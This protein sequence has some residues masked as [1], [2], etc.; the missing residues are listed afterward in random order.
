MFLASA[1]NI[2][3]NIRKGGALYDRIYF[4]CCKD[5]IQRI[6]YSVYNGIVIENIEAN[7]AITRAR[8]HSN[9]ICQSQNR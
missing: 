8:I 5:T 7:G 4:T 3:L 9:C 6:A 2:N 1:S